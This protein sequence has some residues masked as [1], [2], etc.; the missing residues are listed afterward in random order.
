MLS[1]KFDDL[2]QDVHV[3]TRVAQWS[4]V[5]LLSRAAENNG[6]ELFTPIC[7]WPT[8]IIEVKHENKIRGQ[9]SR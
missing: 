3:T 2:P 5:R 6:G 9:A 8:E 1:F 7:L 4:N